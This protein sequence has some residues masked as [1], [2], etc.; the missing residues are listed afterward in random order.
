LRLWA[1]QRRCRLRTRLSRWRRRW[2]YMLRWSS[3]WLWCRLTLGFSWP[4]LGAL[5]LGPLEVRALWLRL[6][7][8]LRTLEVGPLLILTLWLVL[9]LRLGLSLRL[10]TLEVGPLLV[11]ALWLVL[12]LRLGLGLWLLT[13]EVGPLLVL[14][15]WL[16]LTLRLGLSLRLLPLEVG[17]LLILI[18]ALRIGVW[19]LDRRCLW[20]GGY[21]GW[22]KLALWPLVG[23]ARGLVRRGGL[24]TIGLARS[25]LRLT[26]IGIACGLR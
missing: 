16:I 3:L 7:L 17:P 19:T 21:D 12:A 4:G 23:I 11:L 15:L 20:R 14:A 5:R 18:L 6:S 26:V 10:L 2:S 13:L 1:G 8:R 9:T 24:L 22:G 25:R